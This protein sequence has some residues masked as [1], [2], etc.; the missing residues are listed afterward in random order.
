MDICSLLA[1]K[2]GITK[3]DPIEM[4]TDSPIMSEATNP[5][6]KE[7]MDDRFERN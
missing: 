1:H 5:F 6:I 3:R 4:L 7:F 2:F